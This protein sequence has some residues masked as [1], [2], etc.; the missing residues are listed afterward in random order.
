MANVSVKK[1]INAP[2]N[3]VWKTLSSFREVERYVP[4]ITKSTVEGAGVGAKRTC[5]VSGKSGEGEIKEVIQSFDN[6]AK[7][8]SYAITSSTLPVE[9]YLGTM[10]VFDLGNNTCEVEWS[11]SFEPKGMPEAEVVKMINDVYTM[12]LEGLK[13]LHQG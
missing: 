2:P 13:K 9:N 11:G 7:T 6:D 5:I 8:L 3:E 10:K 12:G 4:L 1:T